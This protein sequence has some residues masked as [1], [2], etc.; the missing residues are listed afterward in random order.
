MPDSVREDVTEQRRESVPE[1]MSFSEGL[2]S[3]T[4]RLGDD[5][6]LRHSYMD[7]G[8]RTIDQND[9]ERAGVIAGVKQTLK[10]RMKQENLT[11]RD[12][13]LE[14]KNQFENNVAPGLESKKGEARSYV[15]D[16]Y[17]SL[18]MYYFYRA[19]SDPQSLYRDSY[20]RLDQIYS[21]AEGRDAGEF[22]RF[23]DDKLDW[24]QDWDE[25]STIFSR[26]AARW[27]SSSAHSDYEKSFKKARNAAGEVSTISEKWNDTLKE[28]HDEVYKPRSQSYDKYAMAY[29]TMTRDDQNRD[30][31][32][33]LQRP[34]RYD[35]NLDTFAKDIY[36][37]AVRF[38]REQASNFINV[39]VGNEGVLINPFE[40]HPVDHKKL[41]GAGSRNFFTDD[42]YKHHTQIT[43]EAFSRG[44]ITSATQEQSVPN[45]PP[46]KRI[47]LNSHFQGYEAHR[48]FRADGVLLPKQDPYIRARRPAQRENAFD[49]RGGRLTADEVSKTGDMLFSEKSAKIYS[50]RTKRGN[51]V[52]GFFIGGEFIPAD[53][54]KLADEGLAYFGNPNWKK[55]AQQE[56]LRTAIRR[57]DFF[58]HVNLATI[59][60]YM[61][62]EGYDANRQVKQKRASD[63][64]GDFMAKRDSTFSLTN[65]GQA[66]LDGTLAGIIGDFAGISGGFA[67]GFTD[68]NED[69]SGNRASFTDAAYARMISDYAALQSKM[70]KLETEGD[71]AIA[72]SSVGVDILTAAAVATQSLGPGLAIGRILQTLLDICNNIREIVIAV[73]NESQKSKKDV[74]FAVFDSII[75]IGSDISA[76]CY[77]AS[78]YEPTGIASTVMSFIKD[79]F[80]IIKSI[81][82]LVKTQ[83]TKNRIDSTSKDLTT[84]LD[85]F[86]NNQGSQSDRELGQAYSQNSQSK[87]FLSLSRQKANRDQV[88]AGFDVATAGLNIVGTGIGLHEKAAWLNPV[89]AAFKIASKVS[90]FIS[91][92]TGKLMARSQRKGIVGAV[93]GDKEL[94]GISGFDTVLQE[95]TGI[96]NKYYLTDLARVFMAIDMHAMVANNAS[97][98]ADKKLAEM[99][100]KTFIPRRDDEPFSDYRQRITLKDILSAVGAQSNWRSV[101]FESIRA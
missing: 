35:R 82:T 62:Y 74:V 68:M 33:V 21:I 78:T 59:Q 50:A 98:D 10:S 28:Y 65:I 57:S 80:T 67:L 12:E 63:I 86:R 22:L 97:S 25:S 61:R 89:S 5:D 23:C 30:E 54:Q 9:P 29:Y 48:Q 60:Y 76:I 55:V 96:R 41:I 36:E 8:D 85:A 93:L 27:R 44:D 49:P 40:D 87:F 77:T 79:T 100:L 1:S 13:A 18:A 39:A 15:I 42:G 2:V 94:D 46:R 101:L 19:Q 37:F 7:R 71:R 51:E 84:A 91:L 99:T 88:K 83:K 95:E 66:A 81:I 16:A 6:N 72:L 92:V 70:M 69:R 53:D 32:A 56:R 17:K 45:P 26:F 64:K 31:G 11:S 3:D 75:N 43:T 58:R 4:A 24:L 38:D 20:N 47:K 90:N 52:K 73:Q 14:L 34:D